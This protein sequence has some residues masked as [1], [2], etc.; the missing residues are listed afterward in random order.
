M[1]NF[2]SSNALAAGRTDAHGHGAVFLQGW[3]VAAPGACAG[4]AF[5]NAQEVPLQ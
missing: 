5:A 2:V 3:L 1:P 4:L